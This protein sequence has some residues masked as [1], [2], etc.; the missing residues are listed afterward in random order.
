MI[1]TIQV[2]TRRL[3]RFLPSTAH[4]IQT[5]WLFRNRWTLTL[6]I[7]SVGDQLPFS[8]E[9]YIFAAVHNHPVGI[10]RVDDCKQV[11]FERK[12]KEEEQ[13]TPVTPTWTCS[14]DPLLLVGWRWHLITWEHP[15]RLR[16]NGDLWRNNHLSHVFFCYSRFCHCF[17]NKRKLENIRFLRSMYVFRIRVYRFH[18]E[19]QRRCPSYAKS[20]K[21]NSRHILMDSNSQTAV[22]NIWTNMC[23]P[24]EMERKRDLIRQIRALE[25]VPVEKYKQLG[26]LRFTRGVYV[27]LYTLSRL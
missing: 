12:K 4:L 5:V 14:R 27:H 6:V 26:G 22:T 13:V 7:C 3:C 21:S 18:H 9:P 25:K 23:N 20:S 2:R 24:Q 19:S 10:T 11:E 8:T 1:N 16:Q 17:N 15:S